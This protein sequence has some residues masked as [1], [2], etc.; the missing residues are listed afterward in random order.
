MTIL[1]TVCNMGKNGMDVGIAGF[2]TIGAEVGRRLIAGMEGLRLVGVTS[3][4]RAKA[5]AKLVEI[6]APQV[7]VL[8]PAELAARAEII[9][10]CAPTAAFLEIMVPALEAG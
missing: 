6:G 1:H 7:P 5:E 2:G 3:G 4:G 10:E 8:T 9:V